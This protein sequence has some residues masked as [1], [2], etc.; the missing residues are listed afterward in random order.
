MT[1]PPIDD[2]TAPR[3]SIADLCEQLVDDAKQVARAE[4]ARVRAIVFRRMV[5][6]RVAVLLAVASALLAQSASLVL[7]VGIMIFLR[8][9]VGIL[10]AT[11]IV[12]ATAIGISALFAWLAFRHVRTAL[13]KEDDLI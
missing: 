4:A 6:G 2:D 13:S 1:E 8:R 7:L 12:T 5:K 3:E 9:Y 11:A 10:G